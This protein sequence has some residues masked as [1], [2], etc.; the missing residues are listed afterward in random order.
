MSARTFPVKLLWAAI[1]AAFVVTLGAARCASAA[2]EGLQEPGLELRH[3]RGWSVTL[4]VSDPAA[5]GWSH[6]RISRHFE[7]RADCERVKART[8]PKVKGGRLACDFTDEPMLV[9]VRE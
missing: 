3:V 9:P 1:L 4:Y 5:Y 7:D 6:K 2:Q 8:L